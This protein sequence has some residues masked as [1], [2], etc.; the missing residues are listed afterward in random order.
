MRLSPCVAWNKFA[1]IEDRPNKG[2][3]MNRGWCR[4]SDNGAFTCEP[5]STTFAMLNARVVEISSS[6][7][8]FGIWTSR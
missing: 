4:V 8:S 7:S 5:W 3:S 6:S 2:W 1:L